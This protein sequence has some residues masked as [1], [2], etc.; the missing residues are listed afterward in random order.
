MLCQ[1]HGGIQ[2]RQRGVQYR[3]LVHS[4]HTDVEL[5]SRQQLSGQ[6]RSGCLCRH[7]VHGHRCGLDGRAVSSLQRRASRSLVCITS[8][9]SRSSFFLYKNN[10]LNIF[11]LCVEQRRRWSVRDVGVDLVQVGRVAGAGQHRGRSVSDSVLHR[12]DQVSRRSGRHC[13][14]SSTRG[15]QLDCL[16]YCLEKYVNLVFFFLKKK[17]NLVYEI[18]LLDQHARTALQRSDVRHANVRHRLEHVLS[19]H[20]RCVRCVLCVCLVLKYNVFFVICM[21]S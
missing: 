8:S 7:C 4:E 5:V 21:L 16:C 17:T 6:R 2:L 20:S 19:L 18:D 14:R 10:N 12:H 15:L 3:R 9:M 11:S 13:Q 1:S